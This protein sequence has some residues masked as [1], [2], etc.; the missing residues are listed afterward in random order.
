MPTIT[1][2]GIELYYER[3]GSGP[4]L[5]F[6]NGSGATLATSAPLIWSFADCCDVVAHD[7]RGLGRTEV[8][9]G[10]YTMA[11]Y[12]ADAM[13][14]LDHLRWETCRII[15]VS[16]GGMVAQE[17]AVSWPQR[18]ERL[19]LVCTS[20]GGAG[21][22][23]YP[24]HELAAQPAAERAAVG[25]RI[26]DTRFTAQWLAEH[27]SDRTLVEMMAARNEAPRSNMQRRGEAEQL[28]ARR[29]HDVSTRLS[30]ITCPTLVACGRY[31]G[32]AP[33]A[34]GQWIA[35][36][37]AG[38]ELRVYARRPRVLHPRPPGIAGHPR[39]PHRS[40]CRF[41]CERRGDLHVSWFVVSLHYVAPLEAIDAAMRA[42]VAFLETHRRAG[43]FIAWGRT[44]PRTGG[45][46]L[47][48]H[49]HRAEIERIVA[50]D[51]FV[52]RGL[53]EIEIVEFLPKPTGVVEGVQRL[54][55][56]GSRRPH[57]VK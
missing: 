11:D 9:V 2:N 19:A 33:L 57:E 37:I 42:H 52:K 45:I 24:L 15:G 41:D 40:G 5:L 26:L 46:I 18:V 17:L 35:S 16:F 12:A 6:C 29:E 54:L 51:P 25:M 38:A 10:P 34:N 50:D 55:A 27:P 47:A 53:A 7:Q 28:A 31:D 56:E 32:I 49:E 30:A 36:H 20:P 4:R 39:V 14:L 22:A 48:C 23:S 21:G 44:V 1:A 13:A 43:I 3:R 8:P